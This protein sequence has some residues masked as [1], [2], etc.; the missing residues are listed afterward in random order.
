MKEE[1]ILDFE[2]P[3]VTNYRRWA[4]AIAVLYILFIVTFLV[5]TS[6]GA[7]LTLVSSTIYTMA[8]VNLFV[9]TFILKLIFMYQ[10]TLNK[11]PKDY[12]YWVSSIVCLFILIACFLN[13]VV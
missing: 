4:F 1:D 8:F 5:L 7:I 11:E 13:L 6:R 12:Q 10:M 2:K 3:Q 9:I